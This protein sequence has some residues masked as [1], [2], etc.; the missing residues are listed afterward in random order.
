MHQVGSSCWTGSSCGTNDS[1]TLH[2]KYC[3]LSFW[4]FIHCTYGKYFYTHTCFTYAQLLLKEMGLWTWNEKTDILYNWKTQ[5]KNESIS[6]MFIITQTKISNCVRNVSKDESQISHN[7]YWIQ[8][9]TKSAET[10]ACWSFSV[11][12]K[13]YHQAAAFRKSNLYN[14]HDI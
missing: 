11:C 2:V 1:V 8:R 12:D 10:R 13:V 5:L 3:E 6:K 9:D 14:E 4:E 7:N